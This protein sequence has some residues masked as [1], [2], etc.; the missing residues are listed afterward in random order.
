MGVTRPAI[1]GTMGS[2]TYFQTTMKARELAGMVR[3]A[4]ETDGWASQSIEERMQRDVNIARIRKTIVPYL[5][6]HPDR[7]FGSF[8]VLAQG[9]SISFEPI[10]DIIKDLP[11]AYRAS[12]AGIGY[13]TI[14][15]GELIA[16]DGQ[17]R[18]IALREV[19]TGGGGTEFEKYA[20]QVADD[21]VCVIFLQF[22]SVQ[23][24]RRIF[25]KVNRNAKPTG[26]GDNIITSEDDGF[27]I[28]TRRLLSEER[29]APLSAVALSDGSKRDL[30]N[31]TSTTLPRTNLSITTISVVYESVRIIL[32]YSGFHGFSEDENPVAPTEVALESAYEVVDGWWHE[33]LS[34]PVFRRV[35]ED[36]GLIPDIRYSTD[37]PESL[38]LRP[39][40][41]IILFEGLVLALERA[42]GA[43]DLKDAFRRVKKVDFSARVGNF[44]S[45]VAVRPDG[46]MIARKES[47]VM[48][49]R[50]LAHLIAPEFESPEQEELLWQD[51]NR[52][53]GRDT[54]RDL[55]ELE[56][57][58]IPEDL[59]TPV[60]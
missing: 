15:S 3:P 47:Y 20:S 18:L 23:K 31:W 52:I 1:Q 39:V 40:G 42:K 26:K 22:E 34:L 24:T 44:W 16:L 12:S 28:V 37:D 41:Q 14:N 32:T 4:R 33:V 5:T 30:V 55:G 43:I 53:R 29:N 56:D 25:N 8:I 2:T 13:L 19:I 11:N 35:L 50:L 58:E 49:A 9:E 27:A 59:P 21:E 54:F 48:G 10:G 7:F 57:H 38:L 45:D 6:E 17:H 60:V 36:P 51:W 46:R